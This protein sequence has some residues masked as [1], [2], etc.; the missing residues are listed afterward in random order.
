MLG[1]RYGALM[2]PDC[3]RGEDRREVA[4]R[5]AVD[6]FLDMLEAALH[7]HAVPREKRELR[8]MARESLERGETVDRGELPN[9]IHFLMEIERGEPRSGFADLGDTQPH[10]VPH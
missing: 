9:R 2:K 4:V 8:R 5:M 7:R 3:E 1:T 10:L 6:R